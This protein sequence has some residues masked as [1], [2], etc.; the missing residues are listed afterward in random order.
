MSDAFFKKPIINSP[1]EY[2]NQHW[3]LDE[4]GQPTTRI[5]ETR[6]RAEYVNPVPRTKR[7]RA[8]KEQAEME[9]GDRVGP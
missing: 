7:Q 6:R 4:Q 3:E 9:F 5:I 1:Y 8:E 2:P